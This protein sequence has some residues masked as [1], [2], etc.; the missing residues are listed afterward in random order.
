MFITT[1]TAVLF[2]DFPMSM[3]LVSLIVLMETA[4]VILKHIFFSAVRL[5]PVAYAQ[6]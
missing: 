1:A 2:V 5:A 3:L 4:S 6:R